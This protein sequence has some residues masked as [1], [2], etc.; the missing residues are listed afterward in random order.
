M[1]TVFI[2]EAVHVA[3][4]ADVVRDNPTLK[5][6]RGMGIR[7]MLVKEMTNAVQAYTLSI[8]MYVTTHLSYMYYGDDLSLRDTPMHELAKLL[9]DGMVLTDSA[10]NALGMYRQFMEM[11]HAEDV[12]QRHVQTNQ[13]D[14]FRVLD[15][16]DVSLLY[17]L[18]IQESMHVLDYFHKS[19]QLSKHY[20]E[21]V[22]IADT[23]T[24][25]AHRTEAE[26]LGIQEA[27]YR[28]AEKATTEGVA[29]EDSLEYYASFVRMIDELVAIG[30]TLKNSPVKQADEAVTVYE[31][32]IR[33]ANAVIETIRITAAAMGKDDFLKALDTPPGYEG[34]TEFNVGDYEYEKALMKLQLLANATHSQPLLYDVVANVD[35]DDTDDRGQVQ[36][37]DTTAPTKVFFNKFYYNAPEVQVTLSGGTGAATG[38]TPNIVS[39]DGIDGTRRY[40]EVELLDESGNRTTGILSW[41]SKG[42]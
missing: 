39:T 2:D 36:L 25:R 10:V 33:A 15:E 27:A 13:T 8:A 24:K 1:A 35:I 40:F 31:A 22:R 7:P 37:T 19:L 26:H 30:E 18:V 23:A 6:K 14:S 3:E 16:A 5:E 20:Y 38:L 29:I 41:A 32:Y 9:A 4:A 17:R 42:W 21:F 12:L 34:F 11:I 28:Q